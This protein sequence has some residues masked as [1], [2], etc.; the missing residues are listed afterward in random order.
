M[1]RPDDLARL[2][3]L[4]SV[5]PIH[6]MDGMP[7]IGQSVG[8]RGRFAYPFR[9]MLDAGVTMVLGSD[10]LVADPNPLWGIHAAVALE[11]TAIRFYQDAAEKMP[12]LGVVR[13]FQWLAKENEQRQAQLE[14]SFSS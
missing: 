4:A 11:E 14:D 9:D 10:C 7:M 12:I 6:A 1:I 8:P 5:Q 13:L 3:I 2:G